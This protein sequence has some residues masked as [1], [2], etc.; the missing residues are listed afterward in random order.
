L[1]DIDSSAAAREARRVID[2]ARGR[3]NPLQPLPLFS[4]ESLRIVL[5]CDG[6]FTLIRHDENGDPEMGNAGYA[7]AVAAI[8]LA[9]LLLG[10][11]LTL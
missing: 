8:V 2:K 10:W 9:V 11:A 4:W 6:R 3:R 7:M 5:T 1:D